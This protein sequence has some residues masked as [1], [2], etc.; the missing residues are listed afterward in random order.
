LT[1]PRCTDNIA[2]ALACLSVWQRQRLAPAIVARYQRCRVNM[3]RVDRLRGSS[4]DKP[5]SGSG[6]LVSATLFCLALVI[7]LV[8]LLAARLQSFD[9]SSMLFGGALAAMC[10]VFSFLSR[11]LWLAH[12][13]QRKTASALYASEASLSQ[14]EERFR[15]MADH[16]QEIFWMIDAH[17]RKA[18][19]VN[20]AY[21]AITGRSREAL[22]RDPLSYAELIHPED[23]P[24]ILAKLDEA[25]STGKFNEQIRIVLADGDSRWIWVVGFPVR[26]GRGRIQKLVG[27]AKDVTAQKRA[28]EEIARNL[29]MAE[30][31]WAEADALRKATLALTQDLEMDSVL[32]TLLRSLLELVPYESAQILLVESDSRVF[33]ARDAHPP[34]GTRRYPL[35]LDATA[36]PLIERVLASQNGV[37]LGD[38]MQEQ[39][40]H[41]YADSEYPH[42]WL[43]VPLIVS[44]R[45]L[46]LLS[47]G[48]SVPGTF[49]P[50]HLRLAKLLAIP[51][52]AAI[53]NARMYECAKIYGAEL[54]KR[55]SDLRAVESALLRF[56]SDRPS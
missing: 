51:A 7:L 24:R 26:D 27:T 55:T 25:T 19:Y 6:W 17:S 9:M 45:A 22:Q 56:H 40:W 23:R 41:G 38:A 32:D 18:L 30:A 48:H 37:L 5:R 20:R 12:Q 44:R 43:G 54:E 31:A 3:Q 53:Q 28:E 11:A 15:Q 47:L 52:A 42:S 49:T 50:E 34:E 35:T 16:I 36:Y 14:S 29:M 21:E 4:D 46:G 2:Q 10:V 13:Q 39:E 8:S 1:P 33:V